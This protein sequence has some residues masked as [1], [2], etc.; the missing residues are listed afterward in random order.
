MT[1]RKAELLKCGVLAWRNIKKM[2]ICQRQA[3]R[4]AGFD[5]YLTVERETGDDPKA[6]I[7][8]AKETVKNLI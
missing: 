4:K 8:L 1:E 3:L 7:I 6:D 2:P 5:G